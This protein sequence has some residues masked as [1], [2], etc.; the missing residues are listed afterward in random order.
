MS[1]VI[2]AL[3][4]GPVWE[5]RGELLKGIG[6]MALISIVSFALAIAGGLLLAAIAL[7]S[8]VTPILL[9]FS[10]LRRVGPSM[11]A[12]LSTLEPVTAVVLAYLVF[13]EM[14]EGVQLLGGALVLGGVFVIAIRRL[15]RG[16]Q[17]IS[18]PVPET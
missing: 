6:T 11:A 15:Q 5:Q 12:I 9:F 13:G 8:T 4:F 16:R 10:G 3:D 18:P 17:S 2:A 7:V 14:L 1:T